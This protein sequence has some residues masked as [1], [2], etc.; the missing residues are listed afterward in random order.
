MVFAMG[1]QQVQLQN[2][3]GSFQAG[4]FLINKLLWQFTDICRKLACFILLFH[5][6]IPTEDEENI[7]G[8]V[9][10]SLLQSTRRIFSQLGVRSMSV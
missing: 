8:M 4:K 3:E 7:V 6:N 5:W 10:H 2:I 1:T 9:E